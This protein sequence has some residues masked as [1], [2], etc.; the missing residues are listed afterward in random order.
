MTKT[1]MKEQIIEQTRTKK[2]AKQRERE[3]QKFS[4]KKSSLLGGLETHVS[5]CWIEKS[6]T[7]ELYPSQKFKNKTQV[8]PSASLPYPFAALKSTQCISG[9]F[10]DCESPLKG[11]PWEDAIL[12]SNSFHKKTKT[13]QRWK[14]RRRVAVQRTFEAIWVENSRG[15]SVNAYLLW[16]FGIGFRINSVKFCQG[17][18]ANIKSF[19][20][21]VSRRSRVS[22]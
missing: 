15:N 17:K 19:F 1:D 14:K 3:Q 18:H 11:T 12:C 5:E 20:K 7:K 6:P 4:N 10:V 8:P 16:L 22:Q 21:S 2:I 13:K 9:N